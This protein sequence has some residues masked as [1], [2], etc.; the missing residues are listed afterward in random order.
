MHI[1]ANTLMV[2]SL[3]TFSYKRNLSI[4][5]S[6]IKKICKIYYQN[7]Y[8]VKK[9]MNDTIL[10][11]FCLLPKEFHFHAS[12]PVKTAFKKVIKENLTW[13]RMYI[14]VRLRLWSFQTVSSIK[15]IWYHLV[16]TSKNSSYLRCFIDS[17]LL[18]IK[19]SWQG[20]IYRGDRCNHGR[21]Y[22]FRYLNPIQTRGRR[23]CPPSQR[24]NLNFP[25]DYVPVRYKWTSDQLNTFL[26]LITGT[27]PQG[28]FGCDLCDGGQNLPP[29]V[30]IGLRYLKM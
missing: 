27:S 29:L 26:W 17:E 28:K 12:V 19:H 3:Y 25:R 4:I 21:T 9:V 23:F 13:C 18:L 5:N 11:F 15:I 1:T 10:N 30:G 8:T 6:Y 24:S 20:C 16:Y 2:C 7:I 22:I 14:Q